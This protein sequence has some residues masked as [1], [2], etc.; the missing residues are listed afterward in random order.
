MQAERTAA[1][2]ARHGLVLVLDWID[3]LVARHGLQMRGS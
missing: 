3:E 1:V 2:A